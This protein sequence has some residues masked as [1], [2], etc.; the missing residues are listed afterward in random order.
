MFT[1]TTAQRR[2]I[3]EW[4]REPESSRNQVRVFMEEQDAPSRLECLYPDN[5][6][7]S[8]RCFHLQRERVAYPGRWWQWFVADPE[9]LEPLAFGPMQQGR[10]S[11]EERYMR[12]AAYR[13]LH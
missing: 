9:T 3:R 8:L 11:A 5:F 13:D 2:L 1:R 12:Y 7:P 10:P 4:L 6:G